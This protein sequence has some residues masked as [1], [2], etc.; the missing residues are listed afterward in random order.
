MELVKGYF[1]TF[2]KPAESADITILTN[3]YTGKILVWKR[4]V[5][6]LGVP[7]HLVGHIL[8]QSET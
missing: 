5:V 1:S 2:S 3:V 8:L 4:G 7:H 6:V